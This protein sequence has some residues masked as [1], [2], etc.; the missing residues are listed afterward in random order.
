MFDRGD[1]GAIEVRL[2]FSPF[3]IAAQGAF[4]MVL[5]FLFACRGGIVVLYHQ[6]LASSSNIS[7][8]LLTFFSYI[9]RR[10][11]YI[12]GYLS[13]FLDGICVVGGFLFAGG[14]VGYDF[15]FDFT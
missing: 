4:E 13:G 1:F 6:G 12:F 9:I 5:G 15:G 3:F 8:C 7:N 10:E 14:A 2:I 11:L